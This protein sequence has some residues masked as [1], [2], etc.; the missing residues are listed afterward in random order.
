MRSR[1]ICGEM[2]NVIA[3]S[4]S[5]VIGVRKSNEGQTS[6]AREIIYAYTAIARIYSGKFQTICTVL[7]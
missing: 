7:P 2:S 1:E 3:K 5:G 4:A 6:L